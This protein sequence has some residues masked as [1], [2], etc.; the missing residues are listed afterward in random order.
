[1]RLEDVERGSWENLGYSYEL[2]ESADDLGQLI[3]DITN[4]EIPLPSV[5]ILSIFGPPKISLKIS[6]AV[7]IHGAWRNETTEGV[8]ASLF[9]ET[10]EMNQD[11]KQQV[12]INV[13]G[14]IG[15]K[16][17][18]GADWNTESTFEYENQLKL[19]YKGY[20]DEI[21]QNVEAGNVSLQTSPLVGGGEALFGIKALFQLGPFSL[22]AIA[23]Q[24][25]SEVEEV[26]VSGGTQKNEFE[27]HAYDYSQNHY[28]VD[29]D[30][31]STDPNL[32]FLKN[33]MQMQIRL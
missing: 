19:Q 26:S 16:L 15:D 31:A 6:G 5:G 13:N 7:D 4:I 14:L 12:Q 17:T 1:M 29:L 18:I 27:I 20:E 11:F 25:K 10:Q 23:S 32:N 9:W 30:Y 28:F 22:T 2:K 33:I 3:K 8:T 21:V 24:K